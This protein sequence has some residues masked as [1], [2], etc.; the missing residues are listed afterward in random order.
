MDLLTTGGTIATTTDPRTGRTA[1]NVSVGGLCNGAA[2]PGGVAVRG[3]ELCRVP[4]WSMGPLDM[5]RVA[6]EARGSARADGTTGVVVTHG[7]STIELTAFLTD[8]YL[9]SD[10]P[11]VFTGAMRRADESDAD[12]YANLHDAVAVATSPDARGRGVLVCFGG[13]VIAAR[14]VWKWHRTAPDPFLACMGD[15]GSVLEGVVTFRNEP[16]R[17]PALAGGMDPRA[18]IV[19]AYPGCGPE[20]A[21][22][23]IGAGMRGI[24]IE[25]LPGAGGVPATMYAAIERAL[26]KNV[27]V[28]ISSRAPGGLLPSPPTGGT[29][30]PLRRYDLISAGALSTEKAW[31]LLMVALGKTGDC[32]E[33]ASIF[34]SHAS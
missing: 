34:R 5:L 32:A 10:T 26:A 33:V 30:E 8:L 6:E 24:V 31:L 2:I 21:D 16:V 23:A 22:A 18:T 9:D 28:V 1:P 14:S 20:A 27:A 25:G 7:T 17:R 11:V 4:S 29:G 15:D 12:G 19:K 3:R 13:R